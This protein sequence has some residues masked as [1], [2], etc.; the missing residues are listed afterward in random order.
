MISVNEIQRGSILLHE[1]KVKRVIAIGDYV[2]FEGF[3]VWIGGSMING[4]PL[5]EKWL[6]VFGFESLGD[7][8]WFK[9][10][11]MANWGIKVVTPS[12]TNPGWLVFQGFINTWQELSN[13]EYCHQLQ[14]LFFVIS[15]K[16]LKV[17]KLPK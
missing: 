4:E 3:K 13:I 6:S 11:E 15:G 9:Q 12:L 14:L 8:E 2:Q 1:G 16:H 10:Y 17:S 7:G 5:S